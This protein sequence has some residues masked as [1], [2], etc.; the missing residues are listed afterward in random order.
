MTIDKPF[1]AALDMEMKAMLKRL[2]AEAFPDKTES[3]ATRTRAAQ[4]LLRFERLLPRYGISQS[5]IEQIRQIAH[6]EG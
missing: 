5:R 2:Q 3:S 6:G 1:Q 4:G